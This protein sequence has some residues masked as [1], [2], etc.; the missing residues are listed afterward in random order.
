MSDFSE[1]KKSTSQT[2]L[3]SNYSENAL[4]NG[5]SVLNKKQNNF[6]H[7]HFRDSLAESEGMKFA[8]GFIRV[9]VNR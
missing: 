9:A 4:F 7:R 6:S 5:F 1:T 8:N 3:E 2:K